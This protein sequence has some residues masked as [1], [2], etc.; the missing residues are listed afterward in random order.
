MGGGE[1]VVGE[2]REE[3][4][5]GRRQARIGVEEQGAL[6]REVEHPGD[7]VPVVVPRVRVGEAVVET[8]GLERGIELVRNDGDRPSGEVGAAGAGTGDRLV[9][10]RSTGGDEEQALGRVDALS[11]VCR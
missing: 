10:V 5:G 11:L 4:V 7:L 2:Q 9:D 6:E 1:V 3:S 8:A